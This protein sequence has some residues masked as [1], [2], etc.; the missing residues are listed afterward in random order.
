MQPGSRFATI[1]FPSHPHGGDDGTQIPQ[2]GRDAPS[3]QVDEPRYPA[4]RPDRPGT[5][6]QRLRLLGPEHLAR[7]QVV[8]RS[9]G[10]EE[11]RAP[12]A[13]PRRPHGRRRLVA[14]GGGEY[15][16]EHDRAREG[17]G[18]SRRLQPPHGRRADQHRF[19]RP[20]LGR[21]LSAG[22]RQAAPLQLHVVCAQ[23]RET[24]CWRLDRIP[25]RLYDQCE[26]DRQGEAHREIRAEK[27]IPRIR[28]TVTPPSQAL[29][30][31]SSA[32][33]TT[34]SSFLRWSSAVM[35]LPKC[36]LA[37]P[38]CGERHRFSSGTNFAAASMRRLSSS[39]DSSSGFLVLTRPSTTFFPFGTKRS[40]SKPPARSVSYSRKNPSTAV[41]PNAVSATASYPPEAIHML[42]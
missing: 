39:L 34:S 35:R 6:L 16:G 1:A 28:D 20:G 8:R 26:R 4:E 37:N 42:M 38:H 22:G 41:P 24:G 25:R 2:E 10:R 23:N 12:R 29:P 15:S 18:Q 3:I 27:V 30:H 21:P 14:L 19:R 13:R 36:V 32:T 33:C 31:T 17:R 40:G 5:G 9:R 7:A 11:L